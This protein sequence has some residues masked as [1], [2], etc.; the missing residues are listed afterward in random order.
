MPTLYVRHLFACFACVLACAWAWTPAVAAQS[1]AAPDIQRHNYSKWTADRFA[2]A[3]VVRNF[4]NGRLI[5]LSGI[6]AEEEEGKPGDVRAKND[7]NG[8]CRYAFDKIDRVLK[9]NQAEPEH[10]LKM[11]VYLT[12]T[13][14]IE[15][16]GKCR[17]EYFS[18]AK[19]PLPAET[20]LIISRLAW[21][22]MLLEVDITA[23]AP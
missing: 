10:I 15:A 22:D 23:L 1:G 21:P 17:N 18:K 13:D 19:A 6:G 5:L 12:R 20:L 14:D 16:F 9:R 7:M 2:E 3:V 4:G 8:Q 11:T